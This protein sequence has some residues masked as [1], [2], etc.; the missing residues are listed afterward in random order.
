M[1]L[2]G[3]HE[4]IARNGFEDGEIEGGEGVF[5]GFVFV[6]EVVAF[7]WFFFCGGVSLFCGQETL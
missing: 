3:G 6:C 7:G 1:D 5:H 4:P 2:L